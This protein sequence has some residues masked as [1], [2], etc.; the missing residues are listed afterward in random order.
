MSF[1]D[2]TENHF[3]GQRYVKKKQSQTSAQQSESRA[4]TSIAWGLITKQSLS[5]T[6]M[7][8]NHQS[9]SESEEEDI[10][11]RGMIYSRQITFSYSK[12]VANK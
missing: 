3:T 4:E 10:Q 2:V 1:T 7:V 12:T 11:P 9:E 8:V 6:P 5:K